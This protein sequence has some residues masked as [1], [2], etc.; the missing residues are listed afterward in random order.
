MYMREPVMPVRVY[1]ISVFGTPLMSCKHGSKPACSTISM[2][3]IGCRFAMVPRVTVH[4][5]RQN[6]LL[7]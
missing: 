5:C 1:S 4:F 7:V 6:S 3:G 2:E